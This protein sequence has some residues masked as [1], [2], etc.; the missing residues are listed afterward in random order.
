MRDT[1][2]GRRQTAN[3]SRGIIF[4]GLL[5]IVHPLLP[6]FLVLA[7]AITCQT[8]CGQGAIT[9]DCTFRDS[10][11]IYA[12]GL[13]VIVDVMLRHTTT[14]STLQIT[15]V[16][17]TQEPK[18]P[19]AN[20]NTQI[21]PNHPLPVSFVT[22]EK[23]GVYEIILTVLQEVKAARLP[24]S[25]PRP[26]EQRVLC[27]TRRQ[28]VVITP[29]SPRLVGDWTLT[30]TRSLSL[31]EESSADSPS[32]WQL[33]YLPPLPKVGEL[34][35]ITDLPKPPIHLPKLPTPFG[36][37][38]PLTSPTKPT[39]KYCTDDG[40]GMEYGFLRLPVFQKHFFS[41]QS[42]RNP[43][44]VALSPA[45]SNGCTW[46]RLPMETNSG[47]LYLIEID[48]PTNIPQTLGICVVDSS[49]SAEEYGVMAYVNVAANIHV[50]EEIVQDT[51]METVATHQCLFRAG[52]H[53][54]LVFINRQPNQEAL[55]RNVRISRVT[56][57]GHQE[58]Q[59]LPK[60]FEGRAQR[61]RIGQITGGGNLRYVNKTTNWADD[62]AIRFFRWTF[63]DFNTDNPTPITWQDVYEGS[64]QLLDTLCRGGY[65][66]VTL[67]VLSKDLSLCPLAS[68]HGNEANGMI[69]CFE[70]MFRRFDNE[71]LT[72]IPAIEFNMPIPSLEQ[73]ARQYPTI[74]EEIY[75]GNPAQHQYNL[76][77][78]AVQQAMAEIVGEL[79]DRFSAHPSF[80][81][82]AIVLSPASYAQLPFDLIPPDDHTWEQFRRESEQT[83]GIAFPDEQHLRQTMP[84]QQFL[85]QKSAERVRF[86][87]SEPKTIWETWVRWRMKKVS[88]FYADLALKMADGHALYILGGTMFDSPVIQQYCTPTLPKNFATHQAIQ[89]LGF[90]LSLLS[91]TESLYF[92]KP[93]Q[94]GET[95]DY[96]YEG[97]N[98]A[99][100]APLFS[101][102]GILS[103]VQFVHTDTDH[104]VTT[105][106]HVQSRKRF[107]RQLAQADVVMFMDGGVSLPFGQEST[108]FDLLDTYRRLPSVAF[109]TF[110]L[111]ADN[112][113]SLQP[114]TIRYNNQ[115]DGM[116]VYIVN[117]APFTVEAEFFF[118][119]DS[120]STMSE[121][122]GRRMIRSFN[123]NPQ[124]VG[125]YT[126]RASL[127][128]YDLLAVRIS[129]TD[130]KIESVLVYR[131]PSF[132]GAE[133][134][135]KRKVDELVQRVHAARNGVLWDGLVNADF[136]L[137]IDAA[138]GITGWQCFGGGLT[139]ELDQVAV[140][141]GQ[142]SVK[143][144]NNSTEP[145]TFLCQPQK[146]PAT[147]R[148]G[149]SMLVG[150]PADCQSLPMNVVLSAKYQGNSFNRFVPVEETLKP[151]LAKVEPNN[152][153]RWHRLL[154]P[155]E[156]LPMES[157]EEVRIGVHLAGTPGHTVWLDDVA[158]N[159]V[160][161]LPNEMIELQKMMLVAEQRCSSGR[162]SDLNSLLESY[163]AQFLFQHVPATFPQPMVAEAKPPVAKEVPT[164]PKSSPT[165]YQRAKGLFGM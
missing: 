48:Y 78:P 74:A 58:D 17:M 139:A 73:L 90:D 148:L 66:G 153:V 141:N 6:P 24:L 46:Y 103:G 138:G 61:K 33:P 146:I 75:L 34:P 108:M 123:R 125:H 65:D 57:P 144:T 19:L 120:K 89:L 36:R 88:S 99:D 54:E 119:A 47:Q 114:L 117:D 97:L 133:G 104:F 21:P 71:G 115:P 59:R 43:E 3:G 31:M 77:H 157:L 9:L 76:L 1:Q 87:Q 107:V 96:S 154:V 127:L 18:R 22:P 49:F 38:T 86:L 150:I 126:W 110:Q 94:I 32:R 56:M 60:L 158:L 111:P 160:L 51:H 41:E 136:E 132:C 122:T 44:F 42:E 130:A 134:A 118:S 105:P 145:G 5:N 62:H 112:S 159:P 143:L 161:F 52:H 164:P 152:G 25:I 91:K 84:I 163:W 8:V 85:A 109:Q 113:S 147:G 16:D 82:V 39:Q 63:A 14:P 142:S 28:F 79:V 45:G 69:D 29:Q 156:R 7:V 128:P 121:L 2:D 10:N 37:L 72:L 11:G 30:E 15:L 50:M 102:S 155:F 40:L 162:V 151:L 124:H 20:F 116:T 55:F 27:E 26:H 53:P 140:C 67:T 13:S 106:A 70:M 4:C 135:F 129:D 100:I 101:K 149:V 93:V 95:Q 68:V 23:E 83:L 64:S 165:L 35:R 80:G 12:P 98:S 92:L 81:G 131:P 137:P